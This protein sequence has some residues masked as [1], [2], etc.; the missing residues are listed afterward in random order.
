MCWTHPDGRDVALLL[1]TDTVEVP[2]PAV[3]WGCPNGTAPLPYNALGFPSASVRDGRHS[4]EHMR[5]ELPPLAGGVG[6]QDR[7]VLD[8][9]PAPGVRT[10][11]GQPWSGASG[12]AVFC[13]DHLIGV[14]I[15]DDA[16]FENRRLHACPARAFTDDPAFTELL[17]RYGD[18]PPRLVRI[19]GADDGDDLERYLRSAR[20]AAAQ[21]P[22][23]GVVPGTMPPLSNIYVRQQVVRQQPPLKDA[24]LG[25]ESLLTV[26]PQQPADEVL[27]GDGVRLVV[28]GPGGGKSSL[29]RTRLAHGVRDWLDD[30]DT[31]PVPV[32]VPAA[33]LNG[34]PLT[35]ALAE[36][37]NAQLR[38]YGLTAPLP[39]DFFEGRPRRGTRWLVLVDGLDEVTSRDGRED[40]LKTVTHAGDPYA[41][42]VATRPVP[43]V[44]TGVLGPE[45]PRYHLEPFDPD[46]LERI[47]CGW[48]RAL[49]LT[50][51]DEAAK[52]F[53]GALGPAGL[54]DL[55]RVPLTMSMLCQLHATA[56]ER[57]LPRGRGE[58]YRNFVELLHG[59]QYAVGTSGA[60]HQAKAAMKQYGSD[61]EAKA[62]RTVQSLQR[63]LAYLAG[64]ELIA[65]DDERHVVDIV[66]EHECAERPE[67]VPEH[68]WRDFLES[69]LCGT[70]LLTRRSDDLVFT[71]HTFVEYF[72]ALHVTSDEKRLRSFFR[73]IFINPARYIPL[74]SY[75]PAVRPWLWLSRYWRPPIYDMFDGFLLD[76]TPDDYPLKQEFLSRMASRRAGLDGFEFLIG[77]AR[78]GT[79]LPKDI[80]QSAVNLTRQAVHDSTLDDYDRLAAARVLARNDSVGGVE[81]LRG[82]THDST[83]DGYYRM[84]AAKDLA[85]IETAGL[86][87]LFRNLAQDRTLDGYHRTEAAWFLAELDPA[88]C[89]DLLLALTQDNTLNDS[90]RGQA[91]RAL[92]RIDP[93]A[94]TEFAD[95]LARTE[96]MGHFHLVASVEVL[97]KVDPEAGIQRLRALAHDRDLRDFDRVQAAWELARLDPADGAEV[98][99]AL[100]QDSTLAGHARVA[101]PV[102]VAFTD[103]E[104]A[105]ELFRA[106]SLDP[107]LH[108]S[109][110]LTAAHR[111]LLYNPS[112]GLAMLRELR[113]DNALGLIHRCRAAAWLIRNGRNRDSR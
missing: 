111:L 53:T 17:S 77:Q 38:Q 45:V 48:F 10:D 31:S 65:S 25:S 8:Q 21:H 59:R 92:A 5:G 7:Y 36:T 91:A 67:A 14:V 44:E 52:R 9:G 29:L 94:G 99:R 100:A 56:P 1:L 22:Y 37:V 107:T 103:P 32:L 102:G 28:A 41:F 80:I 12:S 89:T 23:P 106:L 43:E 55:A 34:A 85:D 30:P 73:A 57:P 69:V 70:G 15:H 76:V 2:G 42:I 24:A 113:R 51:P 40:V 93:A 47:A 84:A 60:V 27:T 97:A 6:P 4:V 108:A 101:A 96:S 50:E 98:L 39:D 112:Q 79:S 81:L 82:L 95:L 87:G 26:A 19:G 110:R 104:G 61:A 58:I 62:E 68:R 90:Q 13:D 54:T 74:R 46:E 49:E 16:A 71:H 109:E 66:Q 83:L 20:L 105:A 35:R 86:T 78:L 75:A 88:N 11:G 72:A 18:G 63:L 3:R 64:N 33:A